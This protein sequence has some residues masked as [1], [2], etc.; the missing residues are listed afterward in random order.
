MHKPKIRL[1]ASSA[2]P[3]LPNLPSFPGRKASTTQVR[4]ISPAQVDVELSPVDAG[5]AGFQFDPAN[6]QR[7]DSAGLRAARIELFD[8]P[9]PAR[10]VRRRFRPELIAIALAVA[11]VG[12][13]TLKPW[14]AGPSPAPQPTAV[15]TGS[16]TQ[17]YEAPPN[18][19][20]FSQPTPVLVAPISIPW[21]AD[22]GPFPPRLTTVD[23]SSLATSDAHTDWGIA[24]VT[25]PG[26]DA[27]TPTKL[28]PVANW[29]AAQ[30]E[31]YSGIH[32]AVLSIPSTK[33]VFAIAATWPRGVSVYSVTFSA[34]APNGMS[35]VTLYPLPAHSLGPDRSGHG[36][37]FLSGDFWLAPVDIMWTA[38]FPPLADVWQ[39]QPWAWPAG[40]YFVNFQTMN[41]FETMIVQLQQ[42]G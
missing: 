13:S 35:P 31:G 42:L 14:G 33:P 23:W 37:G 34:I 16:S 7:G 28:R 12:V 21:K 30:T 1:R 2:I 8:E 5:S 20:Q 32:R 36:P 24:I 15:P 39:A 11:F 41:G 19:N 27:R 6:Q 22:T 26:L 3:P 18:P 38:D 17:I 9:L 29:S 4:P 40:Q 25:V 10:P